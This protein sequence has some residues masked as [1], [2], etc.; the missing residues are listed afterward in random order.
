MALLPT[1]DQRLLQ[2]EARR[3]LDAERPFRPRAAAAPD[4]P[5]WAQLNAQDWLGAAT[6]EAA[7]GFGGLPEAGL[8]A[9]ELGRRLGDEPLDLLAAIAH[10]LPPAGDPTGPAVR[11]AAGIARGEVRPALARPSA[12][13]R[14]G[15]APDG[16]LS[17]EGDTGDVWGAFGA[18]H[19]LVP[20]ARGD[21]LALVLAPLDGDAARLIPHRGFDGRLGGRVE[22]RGAVGEALDVQPAGFLEAAEAAYAVLSS[23]T[24][25]GSLSRA[26]ELSVEHLNVREQF[27]VRLA[28]FQALRHAVAN[29][30]V[31]IELVRSM[32]ALGLEALTTPGADW[33]ATASAVKARVGRA[34]LEVGAIAVQLHGGV[35]LAEEYEVG[36]HYRRLLAFELTGGSRRQHLQR[37]SALR[38]T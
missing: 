8:L 13:V 38:G 33:R 22:L 2:A 37:F 15:K 1:E 11:L 9:Q 29:A 21:A 14:A 34:A 23:A 17:L 32:V 28:T 16:G 31:E 7:G 5:A 18:T 12:C 25:L 19:V 30:F 36:H 4:A 26:L 3:F 10:A 27:G 35:G 24:A 20:T 6:S